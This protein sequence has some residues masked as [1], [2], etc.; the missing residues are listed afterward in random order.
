MDIFDT[1]TQLK[2]VALMPPVHTFLTDTFAS[3]EGVHESEKAQYDVMKGGQAMAPFVHAGTG[4]VLMGRNGFETNEI[5]FPT[6]APERIV[7]NIN[8]KNRT[9]GENIVGGLSEEQRAKKIYAKDMMDMLTAIQRR[10]EW[11]A[12]QV[13]TSGKLSILEYVNE[14]RQTKTNLVADFKFTN[15]YTPDTKWDQ[16]GANINQ[17]LQKM[18]DM[19][20]NGLGVC[21]VIV[22]D[23][24]AAAALLANEKFIKHF[25]DN[26]NASM[27]EINTK[28]IGQGVRFI[29]TNSDGIPMYSFAGQYLDDDGVMKPYLPKGT[30]I[31]GSNGMLKMLHAPVTQV[32]EWGK[33]AMHR[34]YFAKEVPLRYGSPITGSIKNRLTARPIV[35]PY[36][37]DG[38]VVA[39][40]L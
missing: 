26:K 39:T 23:G 28:Y 29:G 40:V 38:W 18:L 2:A 12:M 32:E 30:V 36:N 17:D 4:G 20:Y 16:P 3:D 33:D 31:A 19:V 11:M 37:V 8:L 5:S 15:K 22:M 24:H 21:N 34:T 13:L 7:E 1:I 10:K 14:G 25:Y 35:Y 6:I 9:F 27:G